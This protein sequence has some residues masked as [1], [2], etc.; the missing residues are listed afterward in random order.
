MFS[1]EEIR[2]L[3]KI[4]KNELDLEISD[5]EACRHAAQVINLLVTTYRDDLDPASNSPP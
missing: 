3:Q 2:D 4:L 5:N 1:Q